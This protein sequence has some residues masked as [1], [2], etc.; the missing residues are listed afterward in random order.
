M[1]TSLSSIVDQYVTVRRVSDAAAYLLR[2]TCRLYGEHLD[3]P[4]SVSDLDDMAVS[5]WLQALERTGASAWTRTG[6]RTRLLSIWRFAAR[7]LHCRPPGEVRRAP[8]PEPQPE[9]W[10]LAQVATLLRACDDLPADDGAYLRLLIQACYES[11]LRRGDVWSLHRSA[12]SPTGQLRVRQR[13]TSRA[14]EPLVR[15]ETAAAIL[16]RPGDHPLAC[17]WG[18]RKYSAIWSRVRRTAGLASG[19]CQQLRRTGATHVAV[20]H[21]IDAARAFLGHRSDEMISHY[22]DRTIYRPRGCLP[23]PLDASG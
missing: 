6:H 13:K 18:A 1:S 5:G 15:P 12:I 4:A 16:A 22:L 2:W 3:R 19:A 11:G 23:P 17:P 21:G 10:S 8:A 14:H 9:A 20:E 7:R